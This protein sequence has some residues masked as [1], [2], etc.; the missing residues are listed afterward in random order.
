MTTPRRFTAGNDAAGERVDKWLAANLPEVSRARVQAWILEGRVHVDGLPCRPRQLLAIGNVIDVQPGPAP[1]TSAV[2]DASVSVE[3]VFEDEYL[4]VVNKPAGMVVHPAR[5]HATGTLVNG[6]LAR[7][8]FKQSPVDPLDSEGHLRPGIVH[9]IDKDTSGLL[10]ISKTD[11]VRE[12][13]K[14]QLA[15]HKM[16]RVYQALTCGVPRMLEI[17]THYGRHPTS[18][19]RFSSKVHAG[20]LAATHVRVLQ[21]LA[22]GHAAWVEC[23]LETGRTHQIRVHLMEQAQSP[24]LADPLYRNEKS[25]DPLLQRAAESIGRQALHAG[26]LGFVHPVTQQF[27]HFEVPPSP[28]FIA[29]LRALQ[30]P[31]S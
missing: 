8:T 23:Q 13:L 11:P 14:E 5:G 2:P 3:V 21:V 19:L 6:L 1:T 26:V 9:R 20:K 22:D 16:Q 27:L 29:A 12:G 31:A 7:G 25:S 30:L 24:L 28:D 15:Q 18:R 10:V 17:R 4:M